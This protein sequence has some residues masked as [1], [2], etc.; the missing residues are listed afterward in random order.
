MVR[1]L[2]GFGIARVVARGLQP[3]HLAAEQIDDG[4]QVPDIILG[5]SL[6]A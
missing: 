2:R 6:D 1:R 3:T 4:H 5:A